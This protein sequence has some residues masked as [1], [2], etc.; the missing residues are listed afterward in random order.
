MIG[1]IATEH[2][3]VLTMSTSFLLQESAQTRGLGH[4]S[5]TSTCIM[6]TSSS[7]SNRAKA[8]RFSRYRGRM[9]LQPPRYLLTTSKTFSG[10]CPQ[11]ALIKLRARRIY[12]PRYNGYLAETRTIRCGHVD[13]RYRRVAALS[14]FDSCCRDE[15]GATRVLP[16]DGRP[17]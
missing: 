3:I 1:W 12:G 8:A 9:F 17:L 10:C 13:G 16:K 11:A 7:G 15:R 14:L 4:G 5:G 6:C 2:G